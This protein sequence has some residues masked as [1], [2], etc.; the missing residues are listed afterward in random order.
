MAT[1]DWGIGLRYPWW[2]ILADWSTRLRLGRPGKVI[3]ESGLDFWPSISP[4]GDIGDS[5]LEHLLLTSLV[6]DIGD[7]GLKQ[8]HTVWF[9]DEKQQHAVLVLCQQGVS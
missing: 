9:R 4:V 7:G 6:G 2:G 5:G 1:P 8:F 3:G